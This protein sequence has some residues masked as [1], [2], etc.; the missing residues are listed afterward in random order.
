MVKNY[1]L[2]GPEITISQLEEISLTFWTE[3][4]A[5]VGGYII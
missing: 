3:A 4:V 5:P 2:K 1:T